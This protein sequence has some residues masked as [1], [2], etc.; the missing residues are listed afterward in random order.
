MYMWL[1]KCVLQTEMEPLHVCLSTG[2]L[3][4]RTAVFMSKWGELMTVN[5]MNTPSRTLKTL[6]MEQ[7]GG[8]K[9]PY[10]KLS[11][12][13]GWTS[14]GWWRHTSTV[15]KLRDVM[16]LFKSFLVCTLCVLIHPPFA[17]FLCV[18]QTQ[19]FAGVTAVPQ[20]LFLLAQSRQSGI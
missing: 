17:P 9:A 16:L 4:P 5:Q 18:C 11:K 2:A 13:S 10:C 14:C 12:A 1:I 7:P 6:T 3:T 15:G 19:R 20:Y 8:E